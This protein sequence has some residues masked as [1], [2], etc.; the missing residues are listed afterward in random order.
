MEPQTPPSA[1]AETFEMRE[2]PCPTCGIQ[3]RRTLGLRGGEYHRY[4]LGVAT[5]IVQCER[6][7]LIF[8]NPFPYATRPAELYGDPDRIWRPVSPRILEICT[9]MVRRGR[10]MIGTRDPSLLDVGCGAGH[11]MEAARLIGLTRVVGLEISAA[12]VAEA[13]ERYGLEVV[14]QT[15][16][17]Y[18]RS[19]SE[20]FDIVMLSG[21]LEHVPDPDQ[22]MACVHA[23]TEPGSIVYIDVP[24]EP[25]L[26]THVGNGLNRLR[27][28]QSVLNLSPTWPPYHVFGFNPQALRAL[29]GKHGFRVENLKVWAAPEIHATKDLKDRVK[30]AVGTQINRLANLLGMSN[31]LSAWARRE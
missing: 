17:D 25:S 15:I 8:P 26:L 24:C 1:A 14:R 6:C 4:G 16:E 7:E 22:F 19:T 20:T 3:A 11:L 10:T 13:K 18:T 12:L 23:L 2:R 30:A 5:R 29:L 27:G 28:S 31:N 9:D 21:V